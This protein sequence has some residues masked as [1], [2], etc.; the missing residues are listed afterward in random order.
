MLAVV[1]AVGIVLGVSSCGSSWNTKSPQPVANPQ[2]ELPFTGLD[3]PDDVAVDG[4][5]N[6]Y[7]TDEF[8][9]RVLKLPAGSTTQV[10]LPFTGV[11]VP[12]GV[13]VDTAGDVYVTD[14]ETTNAFSAK[15]NRVLKLPAGSNTQVELPFTGLTRPGAVAVDNVGN[16]YVTDGDLGKCKVLK[17]P[18][19]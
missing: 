3:H 16:V 14:Y 17:L 15:N 10:E 18:A 11:K 8:N 5:G 7:V 1:A 13:A 4:A 2:V 12:T 6:V 9:G 19:G